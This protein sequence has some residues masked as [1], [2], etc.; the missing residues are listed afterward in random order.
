VRPELGRTVDRLKL[1]C[2]KEALN[3]EKRGG[4]R[5]RRR[6]RARVQWQ[7]GRR[8]PGYARGMASA[9]ALV[10]APAAALALLFVTAPGRCSQDAQAARSRP[11]ERLLIDDQ[12]PDHDTTLVCDIEVGAP[13]VVTFA[14]IREANI[15]DPLVRALFSVRELPQRLSA[16]AHHEP[17]QTV[18]HRMTFGDL[19]E[20]E[21]PPA[22]LAEKPGVEIVLGSIGRFWQADYGARRVAADEFRTFADPG[23]AKLAMSFRVAPAGKGRSVLRYEARTATT[24]EAARRQFRRYWR[25]IRPG[26]ALVMRRALGLIREEA[27]TRACWNPEVGM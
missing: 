17:W 7:P 10:A 4:S 24:D 15:L 25:V 16:W 9:A 18:P 26:V 13:P 27:E 20:I 21:P 11:G 19:L 8:S 12:L 14:A 1:G 3:M 5:R 22:V 2:E 6:M 23:Y